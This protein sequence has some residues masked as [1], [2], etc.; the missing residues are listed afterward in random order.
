MELFIN[1]KLRVMKKSEELK[2]KANAQD[3]DLIALGIYNKSLREKRLERF[4]D[5]LLPLERQGYEIVENNHKYT[6]D[7]DTQEIKYGI[8]DYFPKANKI[9][10]R[11][12]NNWIKPGLKWIVTFLLT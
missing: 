5:Y 11:K 10:I 4:E 2:Q 1:L 3:N 6:I 7:T 8:I 12:D 9:L